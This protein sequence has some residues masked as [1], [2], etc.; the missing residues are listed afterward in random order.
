MMQMPPYLSCY[1]S[2]CGDSV[3]VA[4]KFLRTGWRTAPALPHCAVED[5]QRLGLQIAAKDAG[6]L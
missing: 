1:L 2:C 4:S 5:A 3:A 6:A